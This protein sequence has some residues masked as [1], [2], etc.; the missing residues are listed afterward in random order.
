MLNLKKFTSWYSTPNNPAAAVEYISSDTTEHGAEAPTDSPTISQSHIQKLAEMEFELL[1]Q[2]N[3][4]HQAAIV[5]ETDLK[6]NI[7]FVNDIFC[8]ISKY[9]YDELIGHNHRILKSGVH[10][11]SVFID[12][13]QTISRGD[14]WKGVVCNRAKDGS[15]Y[16]VCSTIAPVFGHDGKPV[17]Y[18]SIRF[19]ITQQI[20]QNQ[21]L[22]EAYQRISLTEE[23]LRQN[24]EELA[25]YNDELS[26]TQ[27]EL[28]GQIAALNYAALVSESNLHGDITYVNQTFCQI[29]QYSSEELI[30]ANHRVLKSGHQPDSL[31]VE[32]WQAISK[33][34]HWT[35][36]VKNRAKDGSYYWVQT[37]I[38]P[39]LDQDQKPYKYVSVRFDISEQVALREQLTSNSQELELANQQ[40]Q[41]AKEQLKETVLQQK[42]E[43]DDSVTYAQR[44]QRAMMHSHEEMQALLPSG[45]AVEILYQPKAKVSGDFYWVGRWRNRSVLVVGDG[46]GHGVPGSFLSIMGIASISKLVEDRGILEPATLLDELDTEIKK[47][48]KQQA[49][50][51]EVIQD[52]IDMAICS[53][54]EGRDQLAFAS[55]MSKAYFYHD[56]T[57]IDLPCN[58]RPIGGT[59]Y[60]DE[61][62]DNHTLDLF[63]GDC[64]YLL[65]DGYASQ[66]GSPDPENDPKPRKLGSKQFREILQ[67]AAQLPTLSE[68]RQ[69]FIQALDQWKG[70]QIPQTDDIVLMAIQFKGR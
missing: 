34:N 69:Y 39:I 12:L 17:K 28:K 18:V 62:F 24:L 15:H 66:M 41:H 23:E 57:L 63:P 64:I 10:S 5:S 46:T 4:L 3:A 7:I 42:G 16:W 32:L 48:L 8:K 37:T 43:I 55:A 21:Q 45:F 35:G 31:F 33:G 58:R 27:L 54:T 65:S 2:L 29:S 70:T 20:H 25:A 56:H 68:Q 30:G 36:Q 59:L 22:N 53:I 13:W 44:I 19:E 38:T 60:G 52:S 1:G 6:G 11:D 50:A 47:L 67:A 26:R 9:S 61:I 49:G 51:E 14:T 40:L